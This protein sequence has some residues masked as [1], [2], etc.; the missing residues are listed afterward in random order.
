MCYTLLCFCKLLQLLFC[1]SGSKTYFI[2][3]LKSFFIESQC[4]TLVLI[5][6][7]FFWI[8]ILILC[9]IC[10]SSLNRCNLKIFSQS[11]Y[12]SVIN[13]TITI[14][15]KSCDKKYKTYSKNRF[16]QFPNTKHSMKK[17]LK[18]WF[19]SIWFQLTIDLLSAKAYTRTL[20]THCLPSPLSVTHTHSQHLSVKACSLI[21]FYEAA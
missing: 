20:N 13:K 1:L 8:V 2:Q 21:F 7:F 14:I 3:D 5:S 15:F 17:P 9:L 16:C 19:N 4:Y 6:K 18:I 12:L 11:K 10:K